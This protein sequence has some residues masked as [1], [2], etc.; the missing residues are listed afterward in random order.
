[1]CIGEQI[2]GSSI[3]TEPPEALGHSLLMYLSFERLVAV[4][5]IKGARGVKCPQLPSGRQ[6]LG[7]NSKTKGQIHD[8]LVGKFFFA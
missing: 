6:I 5:D 7:K 1:M 8:F 2:W 3:Y 4:A